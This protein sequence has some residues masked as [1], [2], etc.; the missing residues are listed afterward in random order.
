MEARVPTAKIRDLKKSLQQVLRQPVQTP[1]LIHSL[2]MRIQAATFALL[3]ARLYTRHLLRH[4][5]QTVRQSSD[6]DQPQPLPPECLKE[7]RTWMHR[8]QQWNGRSFL[9][10]T[11]KKTLFVDASDTG[12]GCH[13]QQQTTH[14][15]WN[16]QEA[17]Q[18]INWRELKA[19]FLAI[20][21]FNIQ[22]TNL[23]IRTDNTTS[24]SYINKQGGTRS[25]SLMTLAI[26]L[27]KYCLK[28]QIH[29]TAQH[30][31][32]V[33][34]NIADRE[35]R[36][37]FYKNQWRIHPTAFQTLQQQFGFH[38]VDLFADRITHLLPKYVSWKPDPGALTHDAFSLSWSQFRNPWIN[39]PWNMITKCL[40]KLL[41]E[42]VPQATIVI[43]H[44]PSQ[45]YYPLLETLAIQ[46]PVLL[47]R[48]N[49]QVMHPQA[50][51]P[52][53]QKNWK[54]SVW[55]ISTKNLEPQP[56]SL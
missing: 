56:N 24:L 22:N 29:L 8:L 49:L 25:L 15:Y 6:W 5:N 35:S 47:T 45:L 48:R 12:W 20:Q 40:Q 53:R 50:I 1:R 39:P 32:G 4:K 11:P 27:W 31:P 34:N 44:W 13:W 18:S 2:T 3:P 14:G 36:K 19:A 9:P 52:L 16:Q 26:D 21:S 37:I 54:L 42:R 33:E 38:D 51:N 46:P 30:I 41:H 23:L 28:H 17:Q 7:I 10:Q 43:P 55:H